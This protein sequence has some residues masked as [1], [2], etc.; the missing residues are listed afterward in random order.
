M[1]GLENIMYHNI[2]QFFLEFQ[3]KVVAEAKT[4]IYRIIYQIMWKNVAVLDRQQTTIYYGTG[5]LRAG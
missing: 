5:T 2:A 4:H 3:T 1:H